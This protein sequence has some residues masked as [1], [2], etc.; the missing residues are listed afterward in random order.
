MIILSTFKIRKL[1][2]LNNSKKNEQGPEEKWLRDAG[3][4]C[5]ILQ[6]LQK[7]TDIVFYPNQEE[8][9]RCKLLERASRANKLIVELQQKIKERNSQLNPPVSLLDN[10]SR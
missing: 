5:G 3:A 6:R 4:V 9:L 7:Q 10:S 1:E 2:F 8:K